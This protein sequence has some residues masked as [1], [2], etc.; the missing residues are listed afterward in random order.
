MKPLYLSVRGKTYYEI[1]VYHFKHP[2]RNVDFLSHTSRFLMSY[3]DTLTIGAVSHKMMYIPF[4]TI[5]SKDFL[6]ITV[7]FSGA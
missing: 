4:Y 3:L 5:P 6:Q 1:H 7:H 2:S